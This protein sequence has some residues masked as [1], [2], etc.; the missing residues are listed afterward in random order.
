[1]SE[2]SPLEDEDLAN[3]NDLAFGYMNMAT[4]D[5]RPHSRKSPPSIVSRKPT[6]GTVTSPG[7]CNVHIQVTRANPDFRGF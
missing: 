5:G 3:K 4:T 7:S 6:N 2:T 1:M